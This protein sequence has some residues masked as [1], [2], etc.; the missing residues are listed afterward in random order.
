MPTR[1]FTL[2]EL[3]GLNVP[4]DQPDE[5][6]YYEHVLADEQI[7]ILKYTAQRR[8]VFEAPD[9]GKTYAVEYQAKLDTGDYEVGGDIPDNHGWLRDTVEAVEVEERDLAVPKWLPVDVDEEYPVGEYRMS[10]RRRP[11]ARIATATAT[12]EG[13]A[14]DNAD[15]AAAYTAADLTVGAAVIDGIGHEPGTSDIAPLLAQT[16]ARVAAQRGALPG[17]LS[18]ALL[19]A[20]PGPDDDTPD[21]VGIVARC[22]PDEDT[23]IAWVGDCRAYGWDGTVLR[24]YSEDHSMRVHL[25]H[26]GAPWDVSEHHANWV[27]TSLAHATVATVYETA[28]PDPLVILTSDGVHDQIDLHDLEDLIAALAHDPQQLADA[29]VAAAEPNDAGYRDDATVVVLAQPE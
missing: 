9:D 29:L 8:C 16:A 10:T 2:E 7:G 15:A 17:L 3:A 12:R 28:I 27:R 19:V 25:Q 1:H 24:R 4:P 22:A 14:K 26:N 13:T 6:E 20:D 23:R 21:A 5:I 18:A 11:P